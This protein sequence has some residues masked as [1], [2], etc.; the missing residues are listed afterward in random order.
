MTDDITFFKGTAAWN[1]NSWYWTDGDVTQGPY[2]SK[3]DAKAD[4]ANDFYVE[5][6]NCDRVRGI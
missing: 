2:D 6:A 1:A 3:A 4:V 5:S